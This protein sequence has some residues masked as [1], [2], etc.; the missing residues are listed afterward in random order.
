M[1][2]SSVDDLISLCAL[3]PANKLSADNKTF[4]TSLKNH[5]TKRKCNQ[6]EA[7]DR[8]PDNFKVLRCKDTSVCVTFGV[9]KSISDRF[10][11]YNNF[12]YLV[13]VKQIGTPSANGII[14][15]L[16][17]SRDYE[18]APYAST[19]VLKTSKN[20]PPSVPDNL[21]YEYLVGAYYINKQ[22]A[23]LFVYC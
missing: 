6:S 22:I 4:V 17:Y 15:L 8:L 16:T 2:N 14:H 1:T 23:L 5:L 7:E 13:K 21:F 19:A 12:E 9:D 11:E 10:F 20:A 3:R 18:A